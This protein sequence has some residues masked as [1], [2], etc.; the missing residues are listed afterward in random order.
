MPT[1][2]VRGADW[3]SP[4]VIYLLLRILWRRHWPRLFLGGCRLFDDF[5]Y[6]FFKPYLLGCYLGVLLVIVPNARVGLCILPVLILPTQLPPIGQL[7][8]VW[9]IRSPTFGQ[10]QLWSFPGIFYFWLEWFVINPTVKGTS[11]YNLFSMIFVQINWGD[12]DDKLCIQW[13]GVPNLWVQ[14]TFHLSMHRNSTN[15]SQIEHWSTINHGKIISSVSTAAC[16]QDYRH[17]NELSIP[18]C[19]TSLEFICLL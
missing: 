8:L 6:S 3:C 7:L 10:Q 13:V 5:I 17:G 16:Q 12:W 4:C 14:S 2:F 15:I 9:S 18:N 19:W 11:T 1:C